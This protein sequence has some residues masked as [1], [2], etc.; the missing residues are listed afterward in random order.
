MENLLLLLGMALLLAS[1]YWLMKRLDAFLKAGI[2]VDDDVTD[3]EEN[4]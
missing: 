4:K 1:G 3:E 2:F